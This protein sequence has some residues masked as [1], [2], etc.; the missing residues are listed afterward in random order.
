MV[1]LGFLQRLSG[2]GSIYWTSG[3]MAER[4]F[5]PFR[6]HDNAAA[7]INVTWPLAGGLFVAALHDPG[8][9]RRILWGASLVI[10]IVGAL[11]SGSRAGGLVA[12]LLL[13]LLT[14]WSFRQA[15]AGRFASGNAPGAGA[16]RWAS[17][18]SHG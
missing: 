15:L 18:A 14:T 7:F 6:N 10:G 12:C 13:V 5:G 2:A 9:G 11:V 3:T 16:G 1:A 17:A 4:F 8:I